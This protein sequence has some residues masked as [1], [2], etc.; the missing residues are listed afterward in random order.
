MHLPIG[1]LARPIPPARPTVRGP[2]RYCRATDLPKL[3]A[4]WPHQI[5]DR[6]ALGH[7]R[8]IAKLKRALREERLRGLSGHWTYD[9]ARHSQLLAAYKCEV[10]AFEA[11]LAHGK[12][13]P[14][15]APP[16]PNASV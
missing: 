13:E 2:S 10:A 15:H 9:L 7:A 1:P 11:N 12:K 16:P 5:N 3:V 4:M 14:A 8:L 6:S